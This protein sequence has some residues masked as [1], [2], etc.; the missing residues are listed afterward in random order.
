MTAGLTKWALS[1]VTMCVL[2]PGASEAA[3]LKIT[4]QSD[5][6]TYFS[7][8][9]GCQ[10]TVD[11]KIPDTVT[12]HAKD[13]TGAYSQFELVLV[14]NGKVA[15]KSDNGKFVARCNGC[16]VGGAKPDFV[17]VHADSAS[18]AYAQFSIERLSNGKYALKAD[19]GKYLA[20]CNGCSPGA[21]TPNTV[22]VHATDPNKE[23]YAQWAITPLFPKGQ[24]ISLQ[25]DTG[26][27]FARCNGCQKTVNNKFPDTVTVHVKAPTET[28]DQFEVREMGGGKIALKS[29]NGK[30]V[31]RCNGCIVGSKQ[32][33][34][35]AVHVDDPAAA[36]AQF[37]PVLLNNGKW[38][39]ESDTG[40]YAARCNNCSPGA[41]QA[42]TVTVHATDPNKEAY[43]QWNIAYA[44]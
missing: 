7:R 15:L 26:L 19:T 5:E 34:T 27:Y 13:A 32:P 2:L 35:L 37:K 11:N 16:I 40:K 4:L 28:Y 18:Q 24:K 6:G 31:A 8:C 38:A 36:Y 1:L 23:A 21:S 33:D 39:L 14:G 17:T 20:R 3:G 9:N 25:A 12:T 44:P 43:A 10:K 22:T 41:S 42:N 30:Y 29:D